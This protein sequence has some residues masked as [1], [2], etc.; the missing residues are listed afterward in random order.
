MQ[1]QLTMKV[2]RENNVRTVD[3][4]VPEGFKV[5][6]SYH[7]SHTLG[8]TGN[9]YG[10]DEQH[11]WLEVAKDVGCDV[12]TWQKSK[13]RIAVGHGSGPGGIVRVGDNWL[14]SSFYVA[15]PEDKAE[16]FSEA[17]EAA[18]EAIT[19]WVNSPLNE[20]PMLPKPKYVR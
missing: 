19:A 11:K 14:P 7:P 2:T 5:V 6:A 10:A 4:V 16:A 17:L 8:Y 3:A 18:Q 15:V 12:A 13:T 9:S 1:V 20:G